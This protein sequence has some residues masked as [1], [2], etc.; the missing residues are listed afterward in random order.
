MTSLHTETSKWSHTAPSPWHIVLNTCFLSAEWLKNTLGFFTF[1]LVILCFCTD[2]LV[3][4]YSRTCLKQNPSIPWVQQNEPITIKPPQGLWSGIGRLGSVLP[5][6]GTPSQA[7]RKYHS[8]LGHWKIL[9]DP[10]YLHHKMKLTRS[11]Y[12]ILSFHTVVWPMSELLTGRSVPWTVLRTQNSAQLG[13]Q[14]LLITLLL[15]AKDSVAEFLNC[16]ENHCVS[17][18][19]D[20]VAVLPMCQFLVRVWDVPDSAHL[21]NGGDGSYLKTVLAIW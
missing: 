21:W 6:V 8:F 5:G 17:Y 12:W 7:G 4:L 2:V 16:W 13:K 18:S 14:H 3:F 20:Y 19:F 11:L 1:L 10:L 9:L 15:S